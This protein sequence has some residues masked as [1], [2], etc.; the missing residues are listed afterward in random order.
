MTI[1]Q[2]VLK[3]YFPEE[4]IPS[5]ITEDLKN[6]LPKILP[7]M[8]QYDPINKKGKIT[9][10]LPYSIP[11][12]KAY[13][14]NVTIP[15]PLSFIRLSNTIVDNW[16]AIIDFTKQS[17]I[18]LSPLELSTSNRAIKQPSFDKITKERILRSTGYRY[19][20]KIDILRFYGNVY[21]HSIPWALH[22]KSVSKISRKRVELYGNALDEDVRKMQDGQTMGLPI[23]PDTS[24][25]ISEIIAS[26]IDI[27]LQKQFPDLKGIRVVDDYSLYFKNMGDLEVARAAILRLLKDFELDLNQAKEKVIEL[28]ELVES[29]WYNRLR[30]FK[31]RNEH[32]LQNKDIIAYFDLSFFFS[33]KYPEE[34]ILP[35]SL[36]KISASIFS[37]KNWDILESFLLK[38]LL[39]EPKVLPHTIKLFI[40]HF[41]EFY[42]LNISQIKKAFEEFIEYNLSLDNHFEVSWSLWLFKQL[43]IQLSENIANLLSNCENSVIILITLDLHSKGLIP[44]GLKTALWEKLLT[45]ENLYNEHW[46][47][48]YEAIIK[49]WLTSKVDYISKDPFFKL[50]KDNKVEFYKADKDLDL[51]TMK[52]TLDD[53]SLVK[54]RDMDDDDDEDDSKE[55]NIGRR[56]VG[57][58]KE[59]EV[60]DDA[61]MN[62][63]FDSL[64][65]PKPLPPEDWDI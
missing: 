37:I 14:R 52:V 50:L 10:L 28:P 53:M 7:N 20:L 15:N 18:S 1:E 43:E 25:V 23:G 34:T 61:D 9:K 49:G 41:N 35:Y 57:L 60:D 27:E 8:E 11:K 32:E 36:S 33:S 40:S 13:R 42:P 4:I 51:S 26:F 31:F 54:L 64:V 39:V 58:A 38:C 12:V 16:Q 17:N 3:G 2:L 56:K 47:L 6:V 65:I 63:F 44:N 22:T 24:R 45:Q 5:F 19:L 29:E 48:A 55:K 46:L 62:A 59:K 21:T 30:D